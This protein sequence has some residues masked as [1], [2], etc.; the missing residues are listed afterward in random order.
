MVPLIAKLFQDGNITDSYRL[1]DSYGIPQNKSSEVYMKWPAINGCFDE[2]CKDP[3][4][5]GC[6]HYNESFTLL[7]MHDPYGNGSGWNI[8]TFTVL[9]RLCTSIQSGEAGF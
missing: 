7:Y 3:S 5:D 2:W 9:V 1:M 4:R 8:D 6:H